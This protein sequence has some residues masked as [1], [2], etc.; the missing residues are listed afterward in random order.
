[1]L[2]PFALDS[3]RETYIVVLIYWS[4]KMLKISKIKIEGTQSRTELNEATVTEYCDA[5]T[6]GTGF[7]P[8]TVFFDGVEYWLA[9][10]FHRL[11]A[12]KANGASLV[13]VDVRAGTVEDAQA[14]CNFIQCW[15]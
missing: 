15:R 2:L 14:R 3:L 7:P 6:N 4:K 13:E 5:L 9:D 12:L 8:V 1:V 11:F 10:G